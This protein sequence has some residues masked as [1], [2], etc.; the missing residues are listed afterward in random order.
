MA[1]AAT[2]SPTAADP[3]EGKGVVLYDGQCPFCRRS[4]RSLKRL[5]WLKKFHFQDCNDAAN[6]PKSAVPLDPDKLLEEMHLVTPD[7]ERVHAGFGA[8]R[9]MAWRIPVLFPFAWMLYVPGVP[10]L[11][12]K[13]YRWVAKNRYGL[14]PCDEDGVC[15]LPRKK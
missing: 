6:L 12:N 5:D 4:V 3:A 10:W 2:A 14:V 11:G 1:T 15:R 7:R 9:W 8:F 13:M